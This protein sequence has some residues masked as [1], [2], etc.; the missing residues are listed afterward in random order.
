MQ[1]Y[2]SGYEVCLRSM[3]HKA[4]LLIFLA[5]VLLAGC[6]SSLTPDFDLNDGK[7]TLP[8][9]QTIEH[10][11]AC[12]LWEPMHVALGA[13]PARTSNT[14]SDSDYRTAVQSALTQN[15]QDA[16]KAAPLDARNPLTRDALNQKAAET[17]LWSHLITDNFV[18]DVS[19][20]LQVTNVEGINPSLNFTDPGLPIAPVPLTGAFSPSL[21][22]AVNGQFDGTQNRTFTLAYFID[23]AQLWT[24]PPNCENDP[25]NDIGIVGQL[26]LGEIL[27]DGLEAV[28]YTKT[29]NIYSTPDETQASSITSSMLSSQLAAAGISTSTAKANSV[30]FGSEIDFTV[31]EG[32]AGGPSWSFKHF[33]GPGGAGTGKGGGSSTTGGGSS[34][35]SS[36]AGASQGFLNF[37][38]TAIDSIVVQIGATCQKSKGGNADYWDAI[39]QCDPATRANSIQAIQQ[40]L[41]LYQLR[42]QFRF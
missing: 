31:V 39:P 34:S 13:P 29:Y 2:S 22:L 16:L 5:P 26:G 33:S 8:T 12:E 7:T 32:L 9:V 6:N 40:Q 41:L 38:R 35:G 37:N 17:Q 36:S 42:N 25:N 19:L 27:S 1:I 21:T 3:F 28:E 18:A 15:V 14:E 20:T 10:H 11:V 24:S 30:S 23:L 4:R